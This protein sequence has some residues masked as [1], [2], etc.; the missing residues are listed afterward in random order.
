MSN[1]PTAGAS[2][3]GVSSLDLVPQGDA[4]SAQADA[5]APQAVTAV[6]A[7]LGGGVLSVFGD[8]LDNGVVVS[9]NA[10]GELFVN[11]GA[12][13]VRGGPATVA[14]T[15]QIQVFGQAGNDTITL[16][17]ANGA[18]PRANLF[19]GTGNDTITGGSGA[20]LIFGQNDNDVLNG[21]G[22]NDQL[23]GGSGNDVLTGGDADDQMFGE[24][25]WALRW[26]DNGGLY[27]FGRTPA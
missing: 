15:A 1:T 20:D 23:F 10:A 2:R 27:A 13:P 24:A 4:V 14:N 19:G 26:I 7:N 25:E 22:G 11:N 6:F 21:R 9:R 12:V 16:D 8:S 3:V 17:E 18:L 5:V